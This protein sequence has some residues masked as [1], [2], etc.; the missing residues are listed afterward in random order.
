VRIATS[1]L[2]AGASIV[3]PEAGAAAVALQPA[4][5]VVQQRVVNAL[6]RR[7]LA[8]AAEVLELAGGGADEQLAGFAEEAIRD[9]KHQEFL[10]RVI[11]VAQDMADQDKRRALARSL[12]AAVAGEDAVLD[13][14][15][16]FVR[17]VADL[18]SPHIRLLAA[19]DRDRPGEGQLAG[20]VVRDGWSRQ[21]LAR[22]EPGLADALPALLATLEAHAL[23]D[24]PANWSSLEGT[25]LYRI[26]RRGQVLLRRL[27]EHGA[28]GHG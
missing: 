20:Q 28:P 26:T 17:A 15:F 2:V 22:V 5:E 8:R 11:V 24:H 1:V 6:G 9:E 16:L 3:G 7:R 13:E 21:L 27:Q 23:V 14:E 18:D 25:P 12:A 4:A 19:L 10:A